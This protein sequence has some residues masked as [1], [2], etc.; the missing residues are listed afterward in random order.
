L[1][2]ISSHLTPSFANRQVCGLLRFIARLVGGPRGT[3]MMNGLRV[4]RLWTDAK[5][6]EQ[7]GR[8]AAFSMDFRM[9]RLLSID[10]DPR[11][12]GQAIFLKNLA[13]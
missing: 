13:T 8:R 4:A 2:G 3:F 6:I 11:H 12:S 9:H 5:F 1:P 10:G 7:V